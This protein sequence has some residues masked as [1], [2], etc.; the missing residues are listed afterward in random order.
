MTSS[1]VCE[2]AR[3]IVRTTGLQLLVD[4]DTGYGSPLAAARAARELADSGVAAIQIEDQTLPKACGH[5]EVQRLASIGDFVAT[6]S[7]IREAAPTLVC[8]A[9]TDARAVEGIDSAIARARAYAA[10]GA[11]AIFPEALQD[12][13]EFRQMRAAVQAPLIA[14]MTEFGKSPALTAADLQELGYGAVLFPVSS[15]RIAAAAIQDLDL[16]DSSHRDHGWSRLDQMLTRRELYALLRYSEYEAFDAIVKTMLAGQGS[17][18]GAGVA[19][20]VERHLRTGAHDQR[21]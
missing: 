7:A 19:T 15:L 21:D 2:R 5:L 14:N 16:D 17:E 1:E 3:E 12:I 11:D 8:V 20:S 6:L 13:D 18:Q 4:S 9:R 10:A